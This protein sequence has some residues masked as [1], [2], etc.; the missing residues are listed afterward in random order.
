MDAARA[1][2][3]ANCTKETYGSG[4]SV[5]GDRVGAIFVFVLSGCMRVGE[6]KSVGD[7]EV[8]RIA[9]GVTCVASEASSVLVL[10]A[11]AVQRVGVLPAR[12]SPRL[13]GLVA[14][15]RRPW[16][17]TT[18]ASWAVRDGAPT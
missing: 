7:G 13:G 15:T 1:T 12:T 4:S 10:T 3:R 6:G 16:R 11:A 17:A 8:V 2:V 18:P 9:D 14:A 5:Y